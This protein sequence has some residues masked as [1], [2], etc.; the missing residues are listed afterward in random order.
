MYDVR[1]RCRSRKLSGG[2]VVSTARKHSGL[3]DVSMPQQ[4][5]RSAGR[6]AARTQPTA[7]NHSGSRQSKPGN[8]DRTTTLRMT[9]WREDCG[10]TSNP[11]TFDAAKP[12]DDALVAHLL[13]EVGEA[14]WEEQTR[15]A[16]ERKKRPVASRSADDAAG[17]NSGC[18]RILLLA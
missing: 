5:D 8:S 10:P 11:V 4:Q 7:A 14:K 15:L 12:A 17:D 3:S 9:P 18:G 1:Q 2:L 6:P 16:A 13:L